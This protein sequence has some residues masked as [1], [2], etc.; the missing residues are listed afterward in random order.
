MQQENKFS[1]NNMYGT[2]LTS[3]TEAVK[4]KTEFDYKDRLAICNDCPLLIKDIQVCNP[5]LYLDLK[6][7]KTSRMALKGYRRGCGCLISRKARN[8]SSHCHLG[9]W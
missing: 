1:I 3:D 6:T 8:V 4:S 2:I 7:G 5:D 9:K